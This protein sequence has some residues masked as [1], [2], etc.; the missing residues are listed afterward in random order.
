MVLERGITLLILDFITG[1][2]TYMTYFDTL[3]PVYNRVFHPG[4]HPGRST[5]R[6]VYLATYRVDHPSNSQLLRGFL[7]HTFYTGRSPAEQTMEVLQS[8]EKGNRSRQNLLEVQGNLLNQILDLLKATSPGTF[9]EPPK[10]SD[11][12]RQDLP[13]RY[14]TPRGRSPSAAP[15]QDKERSRRQLGDLLRAL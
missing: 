2:D 15:N 11:L 14:E 8:Q 4:P 9:N 5:S 7:L 3:S 6:L 1:C 12:E 13:D 10:L